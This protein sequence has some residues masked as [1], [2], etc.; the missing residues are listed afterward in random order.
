MWCLD[1]NT[2]G[3]IENEYRYRFG[4]DETYGGVWASQTTGSVYSMKGFKTAST[5]GSSRKVAIER[6]D[7]PTGKLKS[8]YDVAAAPR[9]KSAIVE[10]QRAAFV[11]AIR[12]AERSF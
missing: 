12:R 5:A 4:L 2:A 10:A 8:L 9:D 1:L 7:D 6:G 11:D 3:A